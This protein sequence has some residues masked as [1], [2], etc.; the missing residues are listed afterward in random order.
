MIEVINCSKESM[1]CRLQTLQNH[2]SLF[3]KLTIVVYF[4]KVSVDLDSI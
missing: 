1:S 4:I 3:F 2:V